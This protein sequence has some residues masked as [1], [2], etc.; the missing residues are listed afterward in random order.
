MLGGPAVPLQAV[1]TGMT[2]Q[3]VAAPVTRRKIVPTQS[4]SRRAGLLSATTAGGGRHRLVCEPPRQQ[5]EF[6]AV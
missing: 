6:Q 3:A 5:A 1:G 2:R 4:F